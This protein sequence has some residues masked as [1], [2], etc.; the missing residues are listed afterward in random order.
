MKKERKREEWRE[1]DGG[2][3]KEKGEGGQEIR[4]K[5]GSQQARNQ[6]NKT[7]Q[8]SYKLNTAR[9]PPGICR[10]AVIRL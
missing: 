8:I 2:R 5:R 7:K 4:G 1:G 9:A 10:S 3:K 6:K